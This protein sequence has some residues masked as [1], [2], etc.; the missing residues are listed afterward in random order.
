MQ[1]ILVT[2]LLIIDILKI[3]IIINIIF[4]WLKLLW[5]W[6]KIDF[7]DSILDP[8]YERIKN[9]IP[10]TFWPFDL[11]PAIFFLS[12]V[13]FQALINLYD[14]NAYINYKQMI[15]F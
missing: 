14:P 13:F 2:I 12:L 15:N 7:I 1:H 5:I 4:S 6:I 3:F 11:T 8:I 9:T 10:T